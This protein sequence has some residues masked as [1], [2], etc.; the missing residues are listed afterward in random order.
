ML[1]GNAINEVVTFFV[2]YFFRPIRCRSLQVYHEIGTNFR[3]SNIPQFYVDFSA[4][5][6]NYGILA[7]KKLDPQNTRR[8]LSRLLI[9]DSVIILDKKFFEFF[10]TTVDK[11]SINQQTGCLAVK[12]QRPRISYTNLLKSR[13][14]FA[15]RLFESSVT[16][17]AISK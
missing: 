12:K 15:I 6:Y 5:Q 14:T 8:V 3:W 16:I 17:T 1:A 4:I 9:V 7:H 13:R 11:L 10:H 2:V